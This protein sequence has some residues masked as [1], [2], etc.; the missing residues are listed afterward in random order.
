M[1]ARWTTLL[2]FVC[3]GCA[4]TSAPGPTRRG[5][6]GTDGGSPR[7]DGSDETGADTGG[8]GAEAGLDG[9]LSDSV[10]DATT[11]GPDGF[12]VDAGIPADPT[13]TT[14]GGTLTL[15]VWGE[16]TIR[17]HFTTP[18][19]G[20]PP[21]SLAVTQPRPATPFTVQ[22]TGA[23]IIVTTA[24]IQA[25][26]DKSTGRVSFVDATGQT[27][28]SE[29]TGSAR[30]LALGTVSGNATLQSKQSF[31]LNAGESLF[32]LG[33][34]QQ[35]RVSYNGTRQTLQQQNR[36]IGIPVLTSSR[37]YGILW[38]NPAITT[39]D[40]TSTS[41][42]V[43]SSE[44]ASDI[45]Y[46]FM[47]GPEIDD[48]VADYRALTGAAPMFGRWF[49]GYWQ[50]KE[51]YATQA[52]FLGIVTGYRSRQLPI[53]GIVQD[54][55]YWQPAPWGSHSFDPSRFPDPTGMVSTA[56][57]NNFH[58]LLSVWAKFES[59]SANYDALSAGGALYPMFYQNLGQSTTQTSRYYDPF[60][61]Q[62]RTLYW[63][64]M[65][66]ELFSK[67]FDAWWLD[68]TEPELGGNWGELR[69]VPTAAGLGMKVFNAYPLM[70]TTAVSQGQRAATTQ[71]RVFILTRSAYA[72]QQRNGAVSW[73]GDINGDFATFKLQIPAGLNFSLSGIP[74][75]NT[76]IGGFFPQTAIASSAYQELYT[77]WFQYGA[78]CPM[79]RS[80]G[81][82]G[83]KNMWVWGA[84]A[85][86]ILLGVDQLRYR[87][88]PYIYSVSWMVTSKSSTMMRGFVFDFRGDPNALAVGDQFMFGPA[89]MV[90]PVTA[91]GATS[92]SVY[93]PAG[94]T[95]YDFWTGAT[96]TGGQRVMASAPIDHLPLYVRAGSVVPLGP[97]M[98]YSTERAPDP[99]E[100][101][102]YPGADG[103]FTLYEDEN[104]NYNYENGMHATIP[105]TWNDAA[106]TLTVGARQG[107]Y[108]G[109]APSRTFRVVFVGPNH[110]TAVAETA[111]ADQT[112]TYGGTA[113]DVK[114]P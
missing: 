75:W 77:R 4:S 94:T 78:F 24:K 1:N 100:V 8:S 114:A 25:A 56:H 9:P 61:A 96:S 3:I 110:G 68:A 79:F 26:V 6:S 52:E 55:A 54:W 42:V 82:G 72:G 50:S 11:G 107:S 104:D 99:I 33:Q 85:Q 36:E 45:D 60:M 31:A 20:T 28:L 27:I 38:D 69:T 23:Q 43:W 58:V 13:I 95:W 103:A 97:V 44:S 98:Q 34:H 48:V 93:L 19:S 102:V 40:A 41:A 16:R 112:V 39:L 89:F 92:R 51:H 63:Q 18:A 17:V 47:Y 21:A 7:T 73:S 30:S 87:L 46:Y 109:M 22:D 105:L 76:D 74:Y 53:D 59:G 12:T 101:R 70:T 86:N 83:D 66:D 90:N 65:R 71:K 5:S 2:C 62:G 49:W 108:A 29:S 111:T 64:Q 10:I 57:A 15:E 81:T 91:A 88:L 32:G 106:R 67:G 84:T 35:G 37:G 14:S 113:V 80:H